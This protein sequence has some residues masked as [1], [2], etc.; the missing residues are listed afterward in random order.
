MHSSTSTDTKETMSDT[1]TSKDNNEEM[2]NNDKY[3]NF[4]SRSG[5][6]RTTP[7]TITNNEA[8]P[9]ASINDDP[10]LEATIN[11]EPTPEASTDT[12][13]SEENND[14]KNKDPNKHIPP[15][16]QPSL[17]SPSSSRYS[18]FRQHVNPLAR[19][20]QMKTDLPDNWP[21]SDF[22]NVNL[23]LYLDIGCGKGG[24]LLELVGRRHGEKDAN[25][26]FEGIRNDAYM[27]GTKAFE[28]TTSTWLPSKMNYLGLEIRPGVSQYSQ[29]RVEKRGLSGILS[30]VGCNANVD[31]DRLLSL[32]QESA[33]ENEDANNRP[34]FVSIQFP[35]PHFK[36]QHT[37]R[38]VVT[39]ELVTTLGK[40]MKEGDVVFLQSDIKDAL[41]A[42][43]EKFVEEDGTLYFDEWADPTTKNSATVGE[44]YG[45]ENPLGIP[46]ER[47][48]S[49]LKNDLP[50]YRTLFK[51]NGVG[52]VAKEITEIESSE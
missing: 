50:I 41:E 4:F 1:Q 20:Y 19:K 42:M 29:K 48:V 11:N 18:R 47:E 38:R 31:L 40:F 13:T 51:R 2:D 34:A 49:V 26:S 23:P 7:T 32:Y 21:Y 14:D 6:T 33:D 3:N 36:K 52:F 15:W 10:T 30:F 35:D 28:D 8:T 37:K 17:R 5:F 24:F 46:T 45:M 25:G 39:A 16:S 22:T 27:N 43:R 9:E 12:K 44:E